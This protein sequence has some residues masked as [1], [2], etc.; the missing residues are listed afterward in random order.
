[1]ANQPQI[2]KYDPETTPQTTLL[3][4][5]PGKARYT[6]CKTDLVSADVRAYVGVGENELHHHTGNDGF[7]MVLRGRVA[8]Y[9]EGDVVVA[10]LGKHEGILIPRGFN[11]WFAGIG[12]E[13]LE[14]LH[15]GAKAQT[16]EDRVVQPL[17]STKE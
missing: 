17:R 16:V 14:L 12:D 8:F 2:F 9:G 6:L 1:M 15:V 7:W 3:N 13:R 5:K 4:P 11:Y 10:E